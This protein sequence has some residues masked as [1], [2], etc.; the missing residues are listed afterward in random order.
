MKATL[1]PC[2]EYG[3]AVVTAQEQQGHWKPEKGMSHLGTSRAA[4]RDTGWR[5]VI[6]ARSGSSDLQFVSIF[7]LPFVFLFLVGK[8]LW[9]F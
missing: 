5:V 4:L 1:L 3:I 9:P 6:A 8:E 2:K 7:M